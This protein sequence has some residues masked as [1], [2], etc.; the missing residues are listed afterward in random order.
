[1]SSIVE[2]AKVGATYKIDGEL[3]LY[4]LSESLKQALSYESWYIKMPNSTA[5]HLLEGESILRR[6]RDI[7][8]KFK[9]VTSNAQ[10]QKFVNSIIGVKR[11]VLPELDNN[12]VY[13]VDLI[14]LDVYNKM[15]DSF[16]KVKEVFET[17]S[18]DV[19]SCAKQGDNYLIPYVDDYLISIDTEKNILYVDWEYDYS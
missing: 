2:I 16:G 10:A 8:I 18:N 7:F 12:D 9:D 11:E 14:G 6:G 4:I 13:W 3:K 1:M 15:G 19:L 17:G 5:Y